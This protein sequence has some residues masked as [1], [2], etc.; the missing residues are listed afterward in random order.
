[1][2]V[3]FTCVVGHGH[4]NPMVPLARAFEHAGHEVAF[5][6]DPGFVGRVAEL[7]AW[8]R[9]DAEPLLDS[10]SC[11]TL[12]VG[13]ADDPVFPPAITEAMGRGIKDSTVVIMPRM[14]HDFPA[15]LTTDHIAPFLLR[16]GPLL[17]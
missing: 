3:L 16:D 8:L 13:G 7:E 10:I 14:A 15:R 1:M 4:F 12:V 17:P 5:A 2:R 11:P 9:V 6:T